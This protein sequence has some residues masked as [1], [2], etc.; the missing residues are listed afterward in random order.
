VAVEAAQPARRRKPSKQDRFPHAPAPRPLAL[1]ARQARSY[2]GSGECVGLWID[3]HL[4]ALQRARGAGEGY[5]EVILRL[6]Q[7]T[8]L[9]EP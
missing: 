8:T 5:S 6:A 1:G 4:A 2:G 3:R 7:A 9:G